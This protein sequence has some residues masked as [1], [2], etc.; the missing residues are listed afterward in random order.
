MQ[1]PKLTKVISFRLTDEDWLAIQNA[2]E[3]V[4]ETPN[5]WCRQAAVETINLAGGL[6]RTERIFFAQVARIGWLVEN[7]FQ[8]LAEDKLESDVWKNHRAWAKANVKAISDRT[9]E[10]LSQNDSRSLQLR[11]LTKVS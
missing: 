2:A 3:Q 6:R 11:G 10:E 8:L 5:E 1:R 4:G 7:A 9:L